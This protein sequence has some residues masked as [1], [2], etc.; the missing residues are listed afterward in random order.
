MDLETFYCL[1]FGEQSEHAAGGLSSLHPNDTEMVVNLKRSASSALHLILPSPLELEEETSGNVLLQ[2]D[3]NVRFTSHICFLSFSP[4]LK[5]ILMNLEVRLDRPCISL[6][7]FSEN[8]VKHLLE[9]LHKGH[10][11]IDKK[12]RREFLLLCTSLRINP[13]VVKEDVEEKE[14]EQEVLEHVSDKQIDNDNSCDKITCDTLEEEDKTVEPELEITKK[15][16]LSNK[17]LE[18]DY[19]ENLQSPMSESD[20]ET[21]EHISDFLN[22]LN[23]TALKTNNNENSK[24]DNNSDENE[25]LDLEEVPEVED[26]F[27]MPESFDIPQDYIKEIFPNKSKATIRDPKPETSKTEIKS[28][29]LNF[30]EIFRDEYLDNDNTPVQDEVVQITYKKD[31]TSKRNQGI[32]GKLNPKRD[33]KKMMA[34]LFND[35]DS[36]QE[37]KEV[38]EEKEDEN[39][40]PTPSSSRSSSDVLRKL[41]EKRIRVKD[42]LSEER[43]KPS[44]KKSFLSQTRKLLTSKPQSHNRDEEDNNFITEDHESSESDSEE[45]PEPHLSSESEEDDRRKR[46]EDRKKR[47]GGDVLAWM[48]KSG[49][50]KVNVQTTPKSFIQDMAQYKLRLHFLEDSSDSEPEKASKT[51]QSKE[52]PRSESESS[53]ESIPKGRRIN[54]LKSSSSSDSEEERK[55]RREKKKKKKKKK[56]KRLDPPL[57]DVVWTPSM[58]QKWDKQKKGGKR[59]ASDSDNERPK[60]S[61]SLKFQ[62]SASIELKKSTEF[63]KHK[64]QKSPM[65]MQR[66]VSTIETVSAAFGKSGISWPASSLPKIPK[67]KKNESKTDS[68]I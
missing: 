56:H 43:V 18:D 52:D 26:T 61:K 33:R 55:K 53:D 6:A 22:Q 35:S 62:R 2:L 60:S 64:S 27:R 36:E 13:P 15:P 23:E 5:S 10:V 30:D 42:K 16:E 34:D 3:N 31:V 48:N 25:E 50:V 8:S 21:P 63:F 65:K 49:K 19:L 45:E 32:K 51:S 58:Y 20:E 1:N 4:V 68:D 47:K 7:G 38:E 57:E 40:S 29:A 66:S 59:K 14:K 54:P 41:E 12:S 39:R 37:E 17:D 24:P 28:K 46:L 44:P 11:V 67:L 9:F